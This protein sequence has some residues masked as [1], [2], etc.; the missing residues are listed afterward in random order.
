MK[1]ISNIALISI[2]E[3]LFIQLI[4][5]LI[6]MVIMNKIMFR[7]LNK[8]IDDRTSY[9]TEMNKEVIEANQKLADITADLQKQELQVKT[10]AFR[11]Q[12]N[13][14]EDG[15]QTASQINNDAMSKIKKI[16]QKAEL[17]AEAKITEARKSIKHDS[18]TLAI[19]VMEKVLNRRLAS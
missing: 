6:F 19:N 18:E 17:E 1:I 7:P 2:N 11:L 9:I 10:E 5:F 12:N 14:M 4:C 8:V 15:S 16:R 3:T 13:L